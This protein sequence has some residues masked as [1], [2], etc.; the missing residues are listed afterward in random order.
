MTKEELF[1]KFDTTASVKTSIVIACIRDAKK[2]KDA[3][4]QADNGV[5]ELEG[6]YRGYTD[7]GHMIGVCDSLDDEFFKR[8]F[9]YH[10]MIADELAR[11][12]VSRKKK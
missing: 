5:G 4:W 1:E 10:E 7:V 3:W 6:L 11:Y 9:F 8:M 12:L 2:V